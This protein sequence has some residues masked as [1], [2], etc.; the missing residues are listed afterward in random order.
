MS[1][2]V[3]GTMGSVMLHWISVRY[4]EYNAGIVAYVQIQQSYSRV[5][6]TVKV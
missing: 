3:T 5:L 1:R 4:N 6:S 2:A